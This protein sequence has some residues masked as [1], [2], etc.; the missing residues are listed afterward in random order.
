MFL[1]GRKK[2]LKSF[3]KF[4]GITNFSK[5]KNF[6]RVFFLLLLFFFGFFFHFLSSEYYFLKYKKFFR[7]FVSWISKSSVSWNIRNFIGVFVFQNIRKAFFRENI[8]HFLILVLES[9]ISQ[10]IRKY[11]NFFRVDFRNVRKAF[12]R[13]YQKFSQSEF[14]LFF[15]LGLKGAL[16]RS[17]Y[18]YLK[19][20]TGFETF[21]RILCL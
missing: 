17:I 3:F 6:F 1:G 13:K 15:E 18:C 2:V 16:G 11:K 7:V 4:F 14:F 10:N 8:R 5:Y 20:V 12:L 19:V 9:F 21:S